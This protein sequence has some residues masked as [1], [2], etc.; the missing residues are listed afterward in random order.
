MGFF[1]PVINAAAKGTRVGINFF[2]YFD[3][4]T[5][6]L[7]IYDGAGIYARDGHN[8]YGVGQRNDFNGNPL[9]GIEGLEQAINGEAT[10]LVCTLSGIDK[11]VMQAVNASVADGE[12]EGRQLRIYFGFRDVSSNVALG[13]LIQLG[14][15]LMELPTRVADGGQLRTVKLPAEN[16]FTQR[17]R[18]PF[19]LMTDHDQ[20]RRFPDDYG[21][22]FI[23]TMT[24]RT[25]TWPEF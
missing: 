2:F 15:W 4:K 24:D 5:I 8:W 20:R 11:T 18:A 25:V 22:E 10:Q 21:Y 17:S 3:F 12:V 23:P 9:Q 14:T 6:P 19:A 16:L 7:P 1:D 13:S